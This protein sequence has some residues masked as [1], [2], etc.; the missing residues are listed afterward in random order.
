MESIQFILDFILHI[1]KHLTEIISQYGTLTYL[2]LFLIIFSETGFVVTPFLPGDSLL[3][4]AGALA[5]NEAN[6]LNIHLMAGLLFAAAFLGNMLNY[7]IGRFI[8][9]KVFEKDYRFIRKDYLLRT[10]QFFEKHGGKT[11]IITRFAPILRTFAPFVAGVGYMTYSRFILFNLIGGLLWVLAFLYA[12]Y[13]FGN[14]PLVKNNFSTVVIAI[15]VISL[16]PAV[17]AA[18]KSRTSDKT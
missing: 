8:G 15:I 1:D 18:I 6:G 7:S 16:L 14:V 12:G 11:V 10:H 9:P 17:Y 3:F 5:A 13:F 4:A 2:I